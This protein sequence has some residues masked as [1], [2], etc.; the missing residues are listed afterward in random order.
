M[1]PT[2]IS[3]YI[4]AP[5]PDDPRLTKAVTGIDETGRTTEIDVVTERPLT[6][7]LNSQEIVTMM[8]IRDHPELLALGYLLN[9][10]ML[11]PDDEVTDIDFDDDLVAGSCLTHD[12]QI[13]H[14]PTREAI[15]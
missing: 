11:L 2:D 6:L 1:K 10:N 13:R 7:Y 9:Q 14:A 5:L 15:G 8:T 3:Q 12:G 4:V